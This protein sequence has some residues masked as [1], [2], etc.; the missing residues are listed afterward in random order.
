MEIVDKLLINKTMIHG[1]SFQFP[2]YINKR[3]QKK[4]GTILQIFS[5]TVP[6]I[7]KNNPNLRDYFKRF[8]VKQ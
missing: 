8:H 1:S 7:L 5:G 2:H 4:K 3:S 6:N